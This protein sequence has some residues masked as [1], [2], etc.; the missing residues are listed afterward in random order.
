MK[1]SE[2]TISPSKI[3][4]T[5]RLFKASTIF[6][7]LLLNESPALPGSETFLLSTSAMAL[8]R[9]K[10]GS[11]IHLLSGG[12]RDKVASIGFIFRGIGAALCGF[13]GDGFFFFPFWGSQTSPRPSACWRSP[14]WF[15]LV[16]TD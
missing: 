13:T 5:P 14:Q 12:R 15:D 4:L 7:Y 11:T 16:L 10:C 9:C 2:L 1:N 3:A 8:N 6:G